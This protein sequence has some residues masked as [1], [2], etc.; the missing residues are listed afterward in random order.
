MHLSVARP[1]LRRLVIMECLRRRGVQVCHRA[2]DSLPNA[3]VYAR[4]N[5]RMQRMHSKGFGA[6]KLTDDV[7]RGA[8]EGSE[9][10][11]AL[12]AQAM[13]PQIW[14]MVVARL[15]PEPSRLPDTEDLTQEAW[16]AVQ[17]GIG[18]LRC[19][20]VGGLRGYASTVVSNKV[21]GYLKDPPGM[22]GKKRV[23]SLDETVRRL[24]EEGPLDA[25]LTAVDKSPSSAAR[26][27]ESD[28]ERQ[29]RLG[30]AL[31]EMGQMEPE[32]RDVLIMALFDQLTTGQIA[33]RLKIKRPAAYQRVTRAL[34]R[35]LRRTGSRDGGGGPV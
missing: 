12:V 27:S 6:A 22:I 29:E 16:M 13:R 19:K 7:I 18:G 31:R 32:D 17:K 2:S 26:A 25:F 20:T 10:D 8:A 21:A 14:A 33:E 15:T 24:S 1:P 11:L 28:H 5:P 34:V 9:A 4:T 30:N 35:L 23:T 3:V